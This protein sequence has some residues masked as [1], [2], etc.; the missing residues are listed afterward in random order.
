MNRDTM[1]QMPFGAS[2]DIGTPEKIGKIHQKRGS[3]NRNPMPS[4]PFG[5][6]KDIET[7]EKIGKIHQKRGFINHNP[8]QSLPFGASKDIETHDQIGE[9]Y[10]KRGFMNRYTMETLFYRC[11]KGNLL[12]IVFY[13]SFKHLFLKNN[14]QQKQIFG[15]I[16]SI[17]SG[18]AMINFF[19]AHQFYTP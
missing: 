4:L 15:F 12:S 5:A 9:T 18:S 3:I 2:K 13:E 16:Y 7:P 10:E 1:H 11:D 6:S 19:L 8:M 17:F 14:M